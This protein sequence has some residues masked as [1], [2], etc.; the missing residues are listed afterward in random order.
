[1]AVSESYMSVKLLVPLPSQLLPVCLYGNQ[2][3][4]LICQGPGWEL[5]L[6]LRFNLS[7]WK[8]VHRHSQEPLTAALARAWEGHW[9]NQKKH[10]PYPL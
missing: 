10:T 1:M 5:T 6:E 4:R 7:F 2:G 3:K 8:P 9:T